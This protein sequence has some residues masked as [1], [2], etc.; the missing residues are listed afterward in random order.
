[1]LTI[2]TEDQVT[3]PRYPSG[4][5]APARRLTTGANLSLAMSRCPDQIPRAPLR[6]AS[7]HP[8]SGFLSAARA[9][10]RE[11][12]RRKNI[13]LDLAR[14]DERMLRDIGL[15]RLDAEYEI[16]KPFWRE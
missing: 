3:Q 12:H 9:A 4:E 13:R 7:S 1:M 8:L 2:F 10:L 11:W 6:Q 5:T 15:T 14:L 16:N